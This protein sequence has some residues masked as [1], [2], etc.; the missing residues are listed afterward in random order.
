MR[1]TAVM[2]ST[3]FLGATGATPATPSFIFDAVGDQ[4]AYP[5]VSRYFQAADFANVRLAQV[6]PRLHQILDRTHQ[7]ILAD[8]DGKLQKA[9]ELGCSPGS[10]GTILYQSQWNA[11]DPL[12]SLREI[13]T[14][15]SRIRSD[16]CHQSAILP[17]E[18]FWGST[19]NCRFNLAGSPYQQIDWTTIDRLDIQSEWILAESCAG[20][21]T[22][23]DYVRLISTVS[24]YIRAKN[25]RI[26]I[27]AQ[28][29]FRFTAPATMIE[30]IRTMSPLVD[31]FLL[32]YPLNQ[33][34]EH[35][36]CTAA[37]LETVLSAFR[38]PP[39]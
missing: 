29:S 38:P 23:D 34:L 27:Y 32:S 3:L 36:Y 11:D 2:V 39:Q 20:Q 15:V 21:S 28:L 24:S 5:V 35:K 30:A 31:G 18:Q 14:A 19:G 37:N 17:S 10:P 7:V 13:T 6:D 22:V 33:E 26:A 1:Y 9:L 16:G 25:P 12:G 8:S 4:A